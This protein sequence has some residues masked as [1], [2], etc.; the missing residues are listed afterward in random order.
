M[1]EKGLRREKRRRRRR[2]KMRK[3]DEGKRRK[4]IRA[5]WRYLY[6]NAFVVQKMSSNMSK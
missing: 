3:R 2:K 5:V 1:S 4:K 6:V